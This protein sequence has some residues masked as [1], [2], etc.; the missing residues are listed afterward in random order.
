M[1]FTLKWEVSICIDLHAAS[2][3]VHTAKNFSILGRNCLWRTPM[4]LNAY[5]LRV[6]LPR[7]AH[8]SWQGRMLAECGWAKCTVQIMNH[9][10]HH[11]VYNI[12]CF[13]R[14]CPQVRLFT[15]PHKHHNVTCRWRNALYSPTVMFHE[16]PV[17]K[18]RST[19]FERN[20]KQQLI[21]TIQ[22]IAMSIAD[23]EV[24]YTHSLS[25]S[26]IPVVK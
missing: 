4:L 9:P 5:L 8:C 2:K 7:M 19:K 26:I 10:C 25:C 15:H 18:R 3:E 20:E 13:A 23:E 24:H 11:D 16:L 6:P 14:A 12:W 1:G 22:S 17:E 21:T